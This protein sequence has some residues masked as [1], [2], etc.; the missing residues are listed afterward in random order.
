MKNELELY[1]EQNFE[2]IKRIDEFGV[3]YWYARELA[4][5]LEYS[6]WRNFKKVISRAKVAC[7]NSNNSLLDH[8][9]EITKM[10][11]IGSN[12]ERKIEDFKLSRY[13]CYLI[14]QNA[15]ASK[16]IVALGQTYFAIQTR[17]QELLDEEIK[18][19]SE[20]EKKIT[21]ALSSKRRK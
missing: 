5:V 17:R 15:D 4:K 21:I 8:F 20:D 11:T 19:L 16:P 12:T 6:D 18:Q 14:V 1:K 3:E 7:E 9:V 2:E 13:M 10:V